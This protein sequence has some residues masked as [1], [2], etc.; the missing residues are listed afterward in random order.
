MIVY[1][2]LSSIEADLGIPL[3][4]LYAVSNNI[5][6][7]YRSVTVP[8]KSGGTRVLSVPDEILKRIQRR[9]ADVILSYSPISRHATA[10]RSGATVQRNALP[11]LAKFSVLKLDI[12]HFFDSITYSAVKDRCFPSKRFSEQ[13]R[14]L[15]TMLCYRGDALPQGAP[16]SPTITNIIMFDF[17]ETVGSFC[18]ERNISYTRY[19]DDMTFSGD[20]DVAEL[21]AFV[22]QELFKNGFILNKEKTTFTTKGKRQ[23][24][25]GIVVND[26]LSTPANY[27]KAIRQQMHYINKFGL[28]SYLA[29]IETTESKSKY[30]EK[31]LG[32]ITFILKTAPNS[33]EFLNYKMTI[34]AMLKA[35]PK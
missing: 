6:A 2:E 23:T 11:H 21:L 8:K 12:K 26:K 17:D 1:N 13:I 9:I 20:F 15:L 35:L 27:R 10:Y 4:T 34:I 31:L 14:I 25:T 28:E 5:S 22:K 18:K 24:V 33:K 7:H 30:L 29:K 32:R 3:T 19:C 16:S